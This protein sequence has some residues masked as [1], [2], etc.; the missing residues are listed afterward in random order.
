LSE[1]IPVEPDARARVGYG[2]SLFEL[3]RDQHVG[4]PASY[5]LI[6]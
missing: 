2:N 3:W 4:F 5:L 6:G 1:A